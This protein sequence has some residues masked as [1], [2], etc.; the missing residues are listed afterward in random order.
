MKY[1]KNL[2]K[3]GKKLLIEYKGKFNMNSED[4]II[5]FLL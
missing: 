5:N 3:I 2:K 4:G 1:L